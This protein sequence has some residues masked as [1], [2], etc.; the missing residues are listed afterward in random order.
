MLILGTIRTPA[1]KQQFIL[2]GGFRLVWVTGFNHN[3]L[4]S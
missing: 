2:P 1:G 4:F 3:T